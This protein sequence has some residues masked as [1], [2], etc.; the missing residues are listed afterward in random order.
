MLLS[1]KTNHYGSDA[2]FLFIYLNSD[3]MVYVSNGGD[4][5]RA[6]TN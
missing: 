2:R 5:E 1:S 3:E 4:G 6:V